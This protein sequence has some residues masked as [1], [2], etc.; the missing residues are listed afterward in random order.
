[1]RQ[2]PLWQQAGSYPASLDRQLLAARWPTGG[3]SGGV[4]SKTAGTMD[5]VIQAGRCAVPLQAGQGTALCTWDA[6]ETVTLAQLAT[7]GQER[8]DVICAQVHD[9]LIDGGGV[10]D[11]AFVAV[12]GPVS[13]AGTNARPVIP[14]NT[15][16]LADVVV[17]GGA[18]NL[19]GAAVTRR[20]CS[21]LSDADPWIKYAPRFWTD[22]GAPAVGDGTLEGLYRLR[23]VTLDLHII[24]R[25]GAGTNGGAGDFHFGLP[26]GIVGAAGWSIE[27]I[28]GV[29]HAYISAQNVNYSGLCRISG[30]HLDPF[31][32]NSQSEPYQFAAC[33]TRV[34]QGVGS[35]VP[36]VPGHFS[37]ENGCVCAMYG[38]FAVQPAAGL[39]MG[40]L[41]GLEVEQLPDVR[42][43]TT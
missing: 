7:S 15:Y 22:S 3:L 6:P 27:Q 13:P 4:V 20:P 12:S 21:V 38:T 31:F 14:P 10:N 23:G 16:A 1:M 18:A 24:M 26:L 28:P 9:D 34:G 39:S 8:L 17:V 30:D 33:N 25:F 5:V 41:P 32:P 35:G 11:F 29:S 40:T 37:F 43:D 2:A 42:G 36:A 19:D